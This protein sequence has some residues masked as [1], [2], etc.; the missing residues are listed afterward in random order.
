[1]ASALKSVVGASETRG[2]AEAP[3]ASTEMI[4][5]SALD[6]AVIRLSSGLKTVSRS[7]TCLHPTALSPSEI[8]H[9]DKAGPASKLDNAR[10]VQSL[11]F[12][13][14]CKAFDEQCAIALQIV[15]QACVE[16]ALCC[17]IFLRCFVANNV[18]VCIS[19]YGSC[20]SP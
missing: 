4:L 18:A 20:T 10:L 14:S 12:M 8:L 19:S 9:Y 5:C 17:K 2:I 7:W 15:C 3:E 13:K 11:R 1:M 6:S 16:P